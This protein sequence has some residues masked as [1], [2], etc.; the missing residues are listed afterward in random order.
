MRARPLPHKSIGKSR[1]FLPPVPPQG[2]KGAANSRSSRELA[3]LSSQVPPFVC[4]ARPDVE[5][6]WQT[7]SA[8]QH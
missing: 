2:S 3:A 5:P 8:R 7:V 1:N 4:S 6:A